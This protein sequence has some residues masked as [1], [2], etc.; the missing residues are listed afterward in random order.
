MVWGRLWTVILI[1]V[2]ACRPAYWPADPCIVLVTSVTDLND[3][4]ARG[5]VC[6]LMSFGLLTT[7]TDI[8]AHG[9]AC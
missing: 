6:W 3:L 1:H 7:V 2:Q 8:L 4:L 5:L 9:L